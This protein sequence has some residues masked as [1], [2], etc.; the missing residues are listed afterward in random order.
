MHWIGYGVLNNYGIQNAD[1]LRSNPV[2]AAVFECQ[3][4]QCAATVRE[5]QRG[6]ARCW[7]S[8]K[9]YFCIL[10]SPG[11]CMEPGMPQMR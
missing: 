10:V 3:P 6:S 4:Q 7:S 5:G 9:K 11:H 8:T 2:K 1:T